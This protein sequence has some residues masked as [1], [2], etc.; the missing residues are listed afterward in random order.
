MVA[1]KQF[2]WWV[3]GDL[4]KRIRHNIPACVTDAIRKTF[5]KQDHEQYETY[6]V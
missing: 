3:R 1:C 2:M 6:L 5:P 4:E